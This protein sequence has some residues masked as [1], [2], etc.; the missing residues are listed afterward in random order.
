MTFDG[1]T[2]SV[3]IWARDLGFDPATLLNRITKLGWDAG[4]ALTTPLDLTMR[5]NFK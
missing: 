5:R 3:T 4:R 1:K 2:Q